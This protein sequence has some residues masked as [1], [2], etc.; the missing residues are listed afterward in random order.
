MCAQEVFAPVVTLHRYQEFEEALAFVNASAFGL[1][2][3][4]FTRD[5]QRAMQAFDALDVGGVLINKFPTFRVENMP[6]GGIKEAASA[7][8]ASVTRWRR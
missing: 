1:Q 5:L 8:K 6:Y 2:A 7:A 4:V 3:G